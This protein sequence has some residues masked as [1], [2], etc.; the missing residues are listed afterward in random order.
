MSGYVKLNGQK[1][2]PK[3]EGVTFSSEKIWSKKTGRTTSNKMVGSIKAIKKTIDIEFP[4]FK[5]EEIKAIEK[6]VS[7]KDLPFFECEIYDGVDTI[8][9]GKVY[10]DTPSYKLYSTLNNFRLYTGYK[11]QLIEQ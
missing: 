7:N 11:V 4:P 6:I 8:F 3:I 2:Y 9:K 1:F 10:S 5:S